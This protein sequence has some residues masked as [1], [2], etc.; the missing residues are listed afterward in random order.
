MICH[1]SAV[2]FVVT[3]KALETCTPSRCRKLRGGLV[4]EDVQCARGRALKLQRSD[5]CYH[6]SWSSWP[7]TVCRL[8]R[9][10]GRKT[11]FFPQAL[12]RQ[13]RAGSNRFAF[14]GVLGEERFQS[15]W[16]IVSNAKA[17]R[18]RIVVSGREIRC[19]PE[20]SK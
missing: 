13:Y 3:C 17:I 5:C 7:H 14:L 9:Q 18:K 2:N 8:L 15:D 11:L 12:C 19:D 4:V 1:N 20:E 6:W 10:R 16:K